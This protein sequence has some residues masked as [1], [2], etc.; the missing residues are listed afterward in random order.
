[1]SNDREL[2]MRMFPVRLTAPFNQKE[3]YWTGLP[4]IFYT[5]VLSSFSLA[6]FV[7]L[8]KTLRYRGPRADA[9]FQK[10]L[11]PSDTLLPRGWVSLHTD[12]STSHKTSPSGLPGILSSNRAL[13]VSQMTLDK[14]TFKLM[15]R[16]TYFTIR[17]G[18]TTAINPN[19]VLSTEQSG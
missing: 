14:N 7:I 2:A 9:T 17:L 16:R 13:W 6:F 12:S 18:V 5:T 3:H 15:A 10:L 11:V 1:M 4:S 8:M 19:N